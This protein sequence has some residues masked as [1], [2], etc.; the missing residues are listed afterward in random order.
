MATKE[1]PKKG[2]AAMHVYKLDTGHGMAPP[3]PIV[4]KKMVS[5]SRSWGLLKRS[6]TYKENNVDQIKSGEKVISVVHENGRKSVSNVVEARKSS[7]SIT[8][9]R[10][11]VASKVEAIN[12]ETMA[13][14]LKAKVLVTDMPGFMQVHA[15][16]CAR[17]TYDCLDNFTPKTLAHNMKKEFDKVYGP[18]WHCIVGSS[19]GS[20]VTHSTG[21]FLYFSMDN[22]Y[23]L[24]FKTKVKKPTD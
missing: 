6:K 18:A 10:K 19:F 3:S 7:V 8:E 23:I 21:C 20:F 17:Q 11:S 16:R 13:G 9:G 15:L 24:V 5:S 12:V 14:F 2:G 22:L 1:K 4:T